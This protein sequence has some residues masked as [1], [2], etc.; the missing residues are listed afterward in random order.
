MTLKCPGQDK[1]NIK[2]EII[3]CPDCGYAI[4]IFSDEIKIRCPKCNNLACRVRLPSCVD[5][6][7]SA[8][9]C[10]GEEKWKLLKGGA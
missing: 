7:K 5:W 2:A 3:K 9:L 6:C 8:R 4:E 10:I 1:R